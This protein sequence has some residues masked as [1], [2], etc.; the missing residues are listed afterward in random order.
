MPDPILETMVRKLLSYRFAQTVFA[1]Q[2]GEPTL[3]GLDFFQR[4]VE[5]EQKHGAPG[6]SV[7][8]ALQT[9]GILID[10][11]WCRLF[12]EYSFLV[13]LSLD[14]PEDIHDRHRQY[15][16][17]KGTWSRVMESA[18][19][20]EQH[21]VEY[22]ILCVVNAHNAPLGADL[23]RWFVQN[24]FPFVQFIPCVE[25]NQP[26][27][28]TPEL[29]GDF[30]IDTF[31][32]WAKEGFGKVSIRDFDALLTTKMGQ[33]G[34]MCIYAPRCNHYIVIEHNGDVYPCDFF[35]FNEW[36]LGN[37]EEAPLHSFM[38]TDKYKQFMYQKDKV[39]A[40]RGCEFRPMC[41]GGCQK[42]RLVGGTFTDPTSLCSA[43]KKFFAY[44]N[45]RLAKLAKRVKKQQ[46]RGS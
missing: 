42:D 36:K 26:A 6:Q 44:A 5:F 39:P 19:L 28:V 38:E 37:I 13:G 12:R 17:G 35:V 40:C 1:W 45:P 32:Y 10:E 15:Q 34:P 16:S 8:N 27:S 21:Q 3:A 43:Y 24:G 46:Q 11:D 41:H 18:R 2:G 7:G 4:A 25:E 30:L 33:A 9:N 22:N 29:L 20:M 31:D 23:L 14:G